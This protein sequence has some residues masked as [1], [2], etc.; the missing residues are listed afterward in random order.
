MRAGPR[1]I[2]NHAGYVE[3]KLVKCRADLLT[4]LKVANCVFIV[5]S[6]VKKM[7]MLLIFI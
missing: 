2:K 5:N 1:N 6:N 4:V 7:R 3:G